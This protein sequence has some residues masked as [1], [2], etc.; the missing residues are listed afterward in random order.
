M[1]Q[2][3][4]RI[5]RL[6]AEG[7]LSAEEAERLRA[8]LEESEAGETFEVEHIQPPRLSR[9]AVAGALCLPGAVVAGLLTSALFN[10]LT[11]LGAKRIPGNDIGFLVGLAVLLTGVVL[12]I[13][14]L[15][16]I[17]VSHGELTGRGLALFGLISQSILLVLILICFTA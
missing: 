7:K 3:R 8:A 9:L 6:L 15:V 2:E 14:A 13:S 17:K 10:T 5:D 4:E 16:V 1:S 12:S 11:A